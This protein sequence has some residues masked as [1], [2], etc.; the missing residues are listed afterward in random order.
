MAT[1][2]VRNLTDETV[3]AWKTR[4]AKKGQS[5]QEYMRDYL[6]AQAQKPTKEELM[7]ELWANHDS[8]RPDLPLEETLR[9]IEET[10]E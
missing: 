9:G 7:E 5:L 10:W 3:R 1:I 8:S 2:Q 4:A 6:G